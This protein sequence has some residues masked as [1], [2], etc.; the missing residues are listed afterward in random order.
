MWIQSQNSLR[1]RHQNIKVT[2]SHRPVTWSHR[3]VTWSHRPVPYLPWRPLEWLALFCFHGRTRPALGS[4]HQPMSFPSLQQRLNLFD[5]NNII[6]IRP[7]WEN[8]CCGVEP[9][10]WWHQCLLGTELPIG[11]GPYRFWRQ[12]CIWTV[13]SSNLTHLSI[14]IINLTNLHLWISSFY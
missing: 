10:G 5:L 14:L 4:C 12:F 2:W 11:S 6:G 8:L 3:P 7:I 13:G 9:V 1:M